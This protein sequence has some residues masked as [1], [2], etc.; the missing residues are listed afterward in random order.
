MMAPPAP[1][2]PVIAAVVPDDA[3]LPPVADALIAQTPSGT[4]VEIAPAVVC[5]KLGAF[6]AGSPIAELVRSA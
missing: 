3:P 6:T 4:V 1:R 5:V 2:P